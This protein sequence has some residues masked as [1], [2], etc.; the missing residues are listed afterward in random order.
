MPPSTSP[1]T[2]SPKQT[3]I[4]CV[5][6]CQDALK[7][8]LSAAADN[9]KKSNDT[10]GCVGTE[11]AHQNGREPLCLPS[12]VHAK[13]AH[14]AV[15]QPP[16]AMIAVTRT[17]YDRDPT[18]LYKEACYADLA[19]HFSNVFPAQQV[20][21]PFHDTKD[22][23]TT[24]IKGD[25]YN[26]AGLKLPESMPKGST[27][28]F[29]IVFQSAVKYEFGWTH[30]LWQQSEIPA[31][32]LLGPDGAGLVHAVLRLRRRR[33]RPRCPADRWPDRSRARCR[34]SIEQDGRR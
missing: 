2:R 12:A 5:G 33:S 26:T 18:S 3:G 24:T 10:P 23:P 20:S 13:P 17:Q 29:P 4:P 1:P 16:M 14:G 6:P 21:G 8:G 30:E 9:L 32:D 11:E 7:K 25:L 15:D 28:V 34:S 19:I 27:K 31:R 22:I